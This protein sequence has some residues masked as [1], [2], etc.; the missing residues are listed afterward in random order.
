MRITHR[1]LSFRWF[2]GLLT[3]PFMRRG[4]S[5]LHKRIASAFSRS[6]DS[7]SNDR[8]SPHAG[9]VLHGKQCFRYTATF[10]IL[11]CLLAISDSRGA[12]NIRQIRS[13]SGILTRFPCSANKNACPRGFRLL[14]GQSPVCLACLGRAFAT[15]AVLFNCKPLHLTCQRFSISL[16]SN[17]TGL[18]QLQSFHSNQASQKSASFVK[19]CIGSFCCFLR[20]QGQLH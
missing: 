18:G 10:G 8:F 17:K 19:H 15:K 20:K 4:F 11:P 6:H 2:V 3:Y 1:V 12:V 14:D 7:S 5:P 13:V 9:C 16:R